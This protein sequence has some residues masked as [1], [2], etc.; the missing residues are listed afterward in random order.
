[1][2]LSR[3][4]RHCRVVYARDDRLQAPAEQLKGRINAL[5]EENRRLESCISKIRSSQRSAEGLAM[6]WSPNSVADSSQRGSATAAEPRSEAAASSQDVEPAPAT[7]P[8]QLPR[9]VAIDQSVALH[10]TGAARHLPTPPGQK[11][12][13][14]TQAPVAD[15]SSLNASTVSCDATMTSDRYAASTAQATPVLNRAAAQAEAKAAFLEA[16]AKRGSGFAEVYNEL[17]SCALQVWEARATAASLEKERNKASTEARELRAC[18]ARLEEAV[19]TLQDRNKELYWQKELQRSAFRHPRDASPAASGAPGRQV[20]AAPLS[21][22]PRFRSPCSTA[23][24]NVPG[25]WSLGPSSSS[26]DLFPPARESAMQK[27]PRIQASS[28]QVYAAPV[29]SCPMQP[30]LDPARL[31]PQDQQ[32]Q[33]FQQGW[34]LFHQL[35]KHAEASSLDAS[36]RQ[37]ASAL[38]LQTKKGMP[39]EFRENPAVCAVWREALLAGA[40]SELLSAQSFSSIA[41]DLQVT[42][43]GVKQ[44]TSSVV[45]RGQCRQW[46]AYAAK[47]LASIERRA[48]LKDQHG[49]P[50]VRATKDSSGS[51]QVELADWRGRVRAQVFTENGEPTR[52]HIINLYGK[53]DVYTQSCFGLEVCSSTAQRFQC[54]RQQCLLL[55]A[56]WSAGQRAIIKQ[57]LQEICKIF[58]RLEVLFQRELREGRQLVACAEDLEEMSF[59]PLLAHLETQIAEVRFNRDTACESMAVAHGNV[60]GLL[61]KHG[62]AEIKKVGEGSFG[63]ALLVR[64][65][66]GQ[67]LICKMVD[68]SKASRKEMEDAVKEGKLLSELKHPYIVRYRESFTESGWLCILMDYC[69]GGDLTARIAE[70]KRGRKPL[71]EDQILRWFV[72]AIMALDYIHKKHV[73]HRDL[74]PSNFFLSKSGNLKMGDFGIA[75]VLACTIAVAKTQIGTP[76]YLSPELCQEKEYNFP[77][78]IWAMGCILYELCARKVPF[79]APNIPGLVREI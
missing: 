4:D 20:W 63:K 33:A 42:E 50:R 46:K 58:P 37:R 14:P 10:E 61:R 72:Q 30:G 7:L 40:N 77:S 13:S 25:R 24:G 53:E 6:S 35:G 59:D 39:S 38:M 78:D 27:S 71:S 69:E 36:A 76:Y 60:A 44:R 19:S 65:E 43:T 12:S 5:E 31:P 21:P 26:S 8:S 11:A 48:H 57:S 54:T 64:S 34:R 2:N 79:D 56:D 67:K 62:Y 9:Q 22:P 28:G 32:T 52:V 74:K 45:H 1:M 75:K 66:D 51:R 23:P 70:A 18:N 68:V 73:L 15:A 16:A 41:T 55:L 29:A 3:S 47:A 49:Q 17:L